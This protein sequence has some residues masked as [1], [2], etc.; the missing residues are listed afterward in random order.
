LP[1]TWQFRIFIRS[2]GAIAEDKCSTSACEQMD[3]SSGVLADAEIAVALD[4]LEHPTRG[5]AG[6][7]S[8]A[9]ASAIWPSTGSG[10]RPM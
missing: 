1:I 6:W 8:V 10:S 4:A 5:R 9:Q 7:G 2:E 3:G